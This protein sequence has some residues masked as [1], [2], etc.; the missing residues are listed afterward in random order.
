M[1]GLVLDAGLLSG[2]SLAHVQVTG[3]KLLVVVFAREAA[4]WLGT[5]ALTDI[6]SRILNLQAKN[7]PD[8]LV[9]QTLQAVF[10]RTGDLVY[11]PSGY[12]VAEKIVH[13]DD[14]GLR[15]VF[16]FGL[17]CGRAGVTG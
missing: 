5:E 11:I 9:C 8:A 14:V 6:R 7:F 13:D 1:N 4:K 16:S 3:G 10:V 12:L 15:P 17:P 2:S